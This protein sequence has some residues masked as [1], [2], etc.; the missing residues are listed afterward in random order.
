LAFSK[1]NKNIFVDDNNNNM[2]SKIIM[3]Y[4]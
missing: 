2:Q 1:Q 3:K 4:L